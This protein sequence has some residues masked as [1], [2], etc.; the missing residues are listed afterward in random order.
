LRK[1]LLEVVGISLTLIGVLFAALAYSQDSDALRMDRSET[2]AQREADRQESSPVLEIPVPPEIAPIA[3][4]TTS[5]SPGT[6]MSENASEIP[7]GVVA[8]SGEPTSAG[9]GDV[10]ADIVDI[11]L[12]NKGGQPALIVGIEATVKR[13]E[14]LG[15]CWG[16]GDI[17]VAGVY[18]LIVPI[19]STY[20]LRV[21]KSVRFSVAPKSVDRLAISIGPNLDD[22]SVGF[23]VDAEFRLV[24]ADGQRLD[25]GSYALLSKVYTPY[26]TNSGDTEWIPGCT[27]RARDVAISYLS[28]YSKKAP[29][30]TR[31]VELF[32]AYLQNR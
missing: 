11:T 8:R 17:P 25:V 24:L 28:A 30:L 19:E 7:S 9:Q 23:V 21:S 18:D 14:Y 31:L 22:T 32:D 3:P 2:E 6:S 27:A 1:H 16:A 15:S 5:I 12:Q 20:P 13:A 4:G 29:G 26:I 10:M